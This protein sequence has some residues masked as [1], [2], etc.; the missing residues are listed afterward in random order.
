[1]IS[2]TSLIQCLTH[3]VA[4][5]IGSRLVIFGVKSQTRQCLN[6]IESVLNLLMI[7][8]NGLFVSELIVM[9][10]TCVSNEFTF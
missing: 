9:L 1:M 5:L 4:I 10:D 8:L 7:S 2:I 3:P 6:C